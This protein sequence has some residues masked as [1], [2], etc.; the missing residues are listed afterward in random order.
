MQVHHSFEERYA[1]EGP[2]YVFQEVNQ[3]SAKRDFIYHN[4]IHCQIL[5][6]IVIIIE[7][8][9]ETEDKFFVALEFFYETKTDVQCTPLLS[10]LGRLTFL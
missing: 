7:L 5:S 4:L 2:C 8:T 10:F 6:L 1:F 3:C 9:D